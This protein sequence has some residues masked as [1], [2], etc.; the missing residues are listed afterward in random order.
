MPPSSNEAEARP[1][2]M[3]TILRAMMGL[4]LAGFNEAE[5]RAPRM[6]TYQMALTVTDSVL[7]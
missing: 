2:R 1:P 4:H 6:T 5:A 7:Q 3:T